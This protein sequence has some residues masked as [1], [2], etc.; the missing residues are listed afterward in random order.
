MSAAPTPSASSPEAT[1]PAAAAGPSDASNMSA[2]DKL[3]VD[4]LKSRGHESAASALSDA[5]GGGLTA[6]N[7]LSAEELVKKM[8]VFAASESG[9]NA[10]KS[11]ANILQELVASG[12]SSNIKSLIMNMG[13]GGAEDALSLDP[14]DK[15]EGFRDLEAW[16]EGSLDM[17]RVRVN[18]L[19]TTLSILMSSTLSLNSVQ[20]CSRYSVTSTLTSCMGGLRMRVSERS[21]SL[22]FIFTFRMQHKSSLKHSQGQYFLNV[23]PSIG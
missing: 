17:Y 10:Y 16:V 12:T 11:S 5:L 14:G 2:M 13:D 4:Y 19:P 23:T 3:V 22:K 6:S 20:S 15:Q 7:T 21:P 9:E 18:V 8:A 1:S